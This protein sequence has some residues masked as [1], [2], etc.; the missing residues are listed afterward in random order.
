PSDAGRE[1][2][3]AGLEATRSLNAC[4]AAQVE[5]RRLR[6]GDDL[7]STLVSAPVAATM[8]EAEITANNTQLVFAGNETT[9]KWMAH[10]LVT[11]ARHPDQRRALVAERARIP[12]A[13][14]E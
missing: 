6:S 10:A 9:A 2:L 3:R 7:I 4:I 5:D 8:S 12:A 14:E 11:L 1:T 13:L